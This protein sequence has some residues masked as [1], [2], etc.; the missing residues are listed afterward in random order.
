MQ[1]LLRTAGEI[2][3]QPTAVK[4]S[5]ASF[6]FPAEQPEEYQQFDSEVALLRDALGPLGRLGTAAVLGRKGSGSLQWHVFAASEDAAGPRKMPSL[7]AQ[8]SGSG[9]ATGSTEC[10]DDGDS[11]NSSDSE[12]VAMSAGSGSAS[13]SLLPDSRLPADE[14][15]CTLEVCMTE[16]GTAA[17]A[18][19][20]RGVD[21]I[22]SA[23]TTQDTGIGA[24]VPDAVVDDYVFDPCGCALAR[25]CHMWV[26]C[27]RR[28]DPHVHHVP[29]P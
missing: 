14:V 17:A 3:L 24:L 16:L 6:L 8:T 27:V 5:R 4:Y 12:S 13:S 19:F 7:S 22:S 2:G 21:F 9:K 25:P 18:R 23:Q 1:A 20:V 10:Y 28:V 11:S 15:P 26:R 29:T